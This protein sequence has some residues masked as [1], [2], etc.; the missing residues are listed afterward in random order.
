[1]VHWVLPEDIHELVLLNVK[2]TTELF[3]LGRG[4]P[5]HVREECDLA[6]V[7]PLL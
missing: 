3:A 4:R 5:S 2:Q 1:M 7:T 6:K